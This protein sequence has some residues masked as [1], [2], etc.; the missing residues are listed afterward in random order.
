MPT[1][2]EAVAWARHVESLGAGEIVLTSMDADGTQNGYDLEMTRAVVDAVGIPVVASGGA[3][4]P[5][6]LR[7]VLA[8]AEASAALAAS[9]FH[10]GQHSIME[11]KEYLAS[12]GVSVRRTAG[13]PRDRTPTTDTHRLRPPP[14][15]P[16]A[17][18]DAP[19]DRESLVAG[20][21]P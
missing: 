8:E 19:H 9:I 5:E 1:G 4:S 17:E 13:R 12:H 7:A 20:S 2:H 11:T 6:H 10:Y 18:R 15:G 14:D 3:G 16:P 21:A